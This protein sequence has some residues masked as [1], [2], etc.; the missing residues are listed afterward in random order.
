MSSLAL[1][2]ASAQTGLRLLWSS[3]LPGIPQFCYDSEPAIIYMEY[4][5]QRKT[6]SIFKGYL[7]GEEHLL[8]TVSGNADV[9]SL[10][11][12]QDGRTVVAY[13]SFQQML[14]VLRDTKL[15]TYRLLRDDNQGENP[16]TIRMRE[17]RR[18]RDEG[19]A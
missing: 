12:S 15:A 1:A 10:S 13:D 11:C 14:F 3:D 4:D 7:N 9:R 8:A 17:C 5:A 16:A 2:T 6:T 18:E 19:R